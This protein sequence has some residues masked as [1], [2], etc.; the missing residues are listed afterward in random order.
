MLEQ[1]A[2]GLHSLH[3]AGL[4]HRDLKPRNLLRSAS[5]SW[6]ITDFGLVREQSSPDPLRQFTAPD[7]VLGTP[8]YLA[9]E[10]LQGRGEPSVSSDI[11][12]LG[13]VLH[14]ALTGVPPRGVTESL[15]D[16]RP[17]LPDGLADLAAWMLHP[18]P[19]ER[20]P[21]TG[22]LLLALGE[23]R[24]GERPVLVPNRRARSPQSWANPR[25][26][27]TFLR[28]LPTFFRPPDDPGPDAGASGGRWGRFL[29]ALAVLA[30]LLL[31]TP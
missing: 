24:R 30:S 31:L 17:G 14:E 4:L 6:K 22:K 21:D 19:G 20:C 13:A 25:H 2:R 8:D 16:L 11:F 26:R 23:L 7:A 18:A 12:S 10:L 28:P 15:D 5:G 9:P 29:G 1:V 3:E 27:S